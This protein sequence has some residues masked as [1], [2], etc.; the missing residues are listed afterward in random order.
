MFP[1]CPF[2]PQ[3]HGEAAW[4]VQAVHCNSNY[5]KLLFI[6][7]KESVNAVTA[8]AIRGIRWSAVR[9]DFNRRGIKPSGAA[10]KPCQAPMALEACIIPACLRKS[11][12]ATAR[13]NSPGRRRLCS[14]AWMYHRLMCGC[15]C[16]GTS[17]SRPDLRRL[18][19]HGASLTMSGGFACLNRAFF[20]PCW[21]SI[22]LNCPVWLK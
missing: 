15:R 11:S 14:S 6:G 16:F 10:I 5:C 9:S 20:C 1:Q 7:V 21:N 17:P 12:A 2:Y 8:R 13:T 19:I 3:F 18:L 4:L 22:C